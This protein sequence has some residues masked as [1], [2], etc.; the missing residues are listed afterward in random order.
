MSKKTVDQK[1]Q[2]VTSMIG[3][4]K[5]NSEIRALKQLFFEKYFVDHD[6]IVKFL[7]RLENVNETI[8]LFKYAGNLGI[9]V[10]PVDYKLGGELEERNECMVEQII[11]QSKYHPLTIALNG[12]FHGKGMKELLEAK[13]YDNAHHS[14]FGIKLNSKFADKAD[15]SKN[16]FVI[17][18]NYKEQHEGIMD[19]ILAFIEKE[20]ETNIEID[21]VKSVATNKK[22]SLF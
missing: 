16:K 18:V 11:N 22:R 9:V 14:E 5:D 10:N 12:G 4:V 3:G 2:Y 7:T 1:Y 13:G 15:P 21:S 20:V 19:K 8:E 6:F 17:D